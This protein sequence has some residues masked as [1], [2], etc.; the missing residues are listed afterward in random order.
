MEKVTLYHSVVAL[1]TEPCVQIFLC[2]AMK[3]TKRN[4]NENDESVAHSSEKNKFPI[5]LSNHVIFWM[6]NKKLKKI[7]LKNVFKLHSSEI[8]C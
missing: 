4:K 7:K 5:N 1:A 8:K 2:F 3:M 6:E